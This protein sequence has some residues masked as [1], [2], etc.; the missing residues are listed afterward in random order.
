MSAVTMPGMLRALGLAVI[1]AV[2]GLTSC[3]GK[4][5]E[6]LDRASGHG[7]AAGGAGG[8]A[9][10]GASGTAGG[11]A[12]GNSGSGGTG[13][14]G[15]HTAGTGGRLIPQRPCYQGETQCID[16]DSCACRDDPR[17]ECQSARNCGDGRWTLA[18]GTCAAPPKPV[19]CPET[20]AAGRDLPCTSDGTVCSYPGDL[21]CVCMVPFDLDAF[22]CRIP[23]G[24]RGPVVRLWYC[25][26][27][28]T[29][30]PDGIPAIGSV[31]TEEGRRCGNPCANEYARV[32]RGGLWEQAFAER[33][34][35]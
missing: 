18:P 33:E 31:C 9:S 2:S 11:G 17:P 30:C 29:A 16:G 23:N 12:A 15:V 4:S 34:C 32:C 14:G 35:V 22:P 7:G 6:H 26:E 1:G 5:E 3:G 25:G 10:G 21:S 13:A 28:T 8:A 19:P 27:A 20:P 24:E